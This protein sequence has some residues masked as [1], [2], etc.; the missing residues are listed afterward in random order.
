MNNSNSQKKVNNYLTKYDNHI[1]LIFLLIIFFLYAIF[2]ALN[3]DRGIIPDEIRH[4]EFSK[5]FSTTLSIPPE[6]PEA[7]KHGAYITHNP[8]IYYW[9]NG[10]IINIV[11][12]FSPSTS[13]WSLLVALRVV[14]IF[15]AIGTIIF[16]YLF[17]KE[18]IKHRWWQLLPVYF[19]TNTIMFV[20]VSG[21]V[22]YDNLANLF[23]FAG[24]F[25][26]ARIFNHNLFITN[27]IAWMIFIALGSLTKF[28][29][30]PLALAMG[31]SWTIFLFYNRKQVLPLK[32]EG[33][34]II[35]FS[36][37][38]LILFIGNVAIYGHNL[39]VYQ[40]LVP[41]CEDILTK[42]ECELDFY[43]MRHKEFGLKE[44]LTLSESIILGYPNPFEYLLQWIVIYFSAIFGIGS[45]RDYKT[46]FRVISHLLIFLW[47]FL[48]AIV[49]KVN[50]NLKNLCFVAIFLF[51]LATLF[52]F[53][54]NDDLISGFKHFGQNGRY[55]F[56]VIGIL[57]IALT[58]GIMKIPH[59]I[60]QKLTLVFAL[61]LYFFTGPLTFIYRYNAVFSDW[62][63]R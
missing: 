39:M 15:Y 17:S 63:V 42:D 51:Y 61:L 26:L 31:I 5:Q 47:V 9:I 18:F 20:F 10:R 1:I 3:I 35:T 36:I 37:L 41:K 43:I 62:F 45:H 21:G 59:K 28:T 7:Y 44:K 57:F 24:L 32:L 8:F 49:K 14:N 13:D 19:L 12:F 50:F 22:N 29:I 38:L 46:L 4:F 40:S 25:F 54:Y 48:I 52:F 11:D 53:N 6:L 16:C 2:I 27:T 56:P 60:V 33:G 23:C 58:K 55:F 30:L 34:K